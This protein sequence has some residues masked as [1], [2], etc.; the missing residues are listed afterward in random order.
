M[1]QNC[2]CVVSHV[3]TTRGGNKW[4]GLARA[5]G[6]W[7]FPGV[8]TERVCGEIFYER[9]TM[10]YFVSPTVES[11]PRLDAFDRSMP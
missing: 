4:R 10:R 3:V 5:A 9:V 7:R 11:R 8:R 2:K 6:G 1:K